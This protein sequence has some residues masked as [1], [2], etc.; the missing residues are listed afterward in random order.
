MS[1][2]AEVLRQFWLPGLNNVSG[3]VNE[4]MLS[5]L[6]SG[7]G[8]QIYS[9]LSQACVRVSMADTSVLLAGIAFDCT[10]MACSSFESMKLVSLSVDLPK[11][12]AWLVIQA[13]YSAFYSGHAILRMLGTSCSQFD[14]V[15]AASIYRVADVFGQNGGQASIPAG[16]YVCTLDSNAKLLTCNRDTTGS[17]VHEAFWRTFSSKIAD[18]SSRILQAGSYPNWDQQVS[19]KLDDIKNALC[20]EGLNGG[21]WLSRIRNE[22]NY[23]HEHS[24]WFPYRK[25]PSYYRDL[26]SA[27]HWTKD[28]MQI[29]LHIPLDRRLERFH[30]TCCAI[31][32]LC[33]VLVKDMALRC[34]G[35]RSF[36]SYGAMS[37]LR[38]MKL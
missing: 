35:G 32:A 2:A 30:A 9:P 34:A 7:S 4:G 12:T 29:G 20:S 33:R 25:Q 6:R 10:R 37:L 15:T 14:P 27:E 24:V 5:W 21:Q 19:L 28:P 16:F 1:I 36:H 17:G 11:S 3:V 18:L 13:Y 38:L 22:V 8:Y 26:H 31:V 23:R